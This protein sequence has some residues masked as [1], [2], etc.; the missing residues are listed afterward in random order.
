MLQKVK[1][2]FN[3]LTKEKKLAEMQKEIDTE[4]EKNGLTDEVLEKQVEMNTL[5]NKL[6]IPDANN[7]VYDKYVQ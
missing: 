4:Y 7:I 1:R 5:R 6:D 2:W 3:K